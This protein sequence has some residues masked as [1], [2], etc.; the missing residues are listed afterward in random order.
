MTK[1]T[2]VLTV[3]LTPKEYRMAERMARRYGVTVSQ[4]TRGLLYG[5]FANSLLADAPSK[6]PKP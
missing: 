2:K 1:R 3:R 4:L 5:S 6:S